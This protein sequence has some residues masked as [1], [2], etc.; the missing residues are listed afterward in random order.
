MG[1]VF[2]LPAHAYP[3]HH[4]F[5][6]GNEQLAIS[7]TDEAREGAYYTCYVAYRTRTSKAFVLKWP[8]YTTMQTRAAC[9]V[10]LQK[11]AQARDVA[12][13]FNSA[14]ALAR[15]PTE[16]YAVRFA[17]A[18]AVHLPARPTGPA[19][20]SWA[21]LEP[22]IEETAGSGEGTGVMDYFCVFNDCN[23]GVV[24]EADMVPEDN[25]EDRSWVED[26]RAT[27]D[28]AQAL[29]CY[30]YFYSGRRFLLVNVQGVKGYYTNPDF[31]YA[32]DAD[33][34]LSPNN[35]GQAGI[36]AFFATFKVTPLVTALLRTL[37]DFEEDWLGGEYLHVVES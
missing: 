4:S 15:Q 24:S 9:T 7:D 12:N 22:D 3:D 25:P 33:P 10:A 34:Y 20:E 37:P 28:A 16:K 8:I 21:L 17:D 26:F 35:A 31:H 6:A 29:S 30:S 5:L 11:L 23:G 14:L 32:D 18:E 36:D 27:N 19:R 1:L 13:A 2:L